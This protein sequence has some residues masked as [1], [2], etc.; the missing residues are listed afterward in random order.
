MDVGKI[1]VYLLDDLKERGHSAEAITRMTAEKAFD[2]YC[3][4]HGL[5]GWGMNLRHAMEAFRKATKP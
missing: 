1:P 4:W 3:E 5:C 2:E